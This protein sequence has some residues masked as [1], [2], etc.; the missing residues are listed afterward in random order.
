[1]TGLTS[2]LPS[3]M[4]LLRS[5]WLFSGIPA[6]SAILCTLA[7]PLDIWVTRSTKAELIECVVACC[8]V[9]VPQLPSALRTGAESPLGVNE[10]PLS[11]S[12]NVQPSSRPAARAYGLKLE[13]VGRG[14]FAQFHWLARKSGPP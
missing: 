2:V 5:H 7:G 12:F 13:P 3:G 4:R 11:L 1:M 10:L 14:L 6:D 9:T 8:S